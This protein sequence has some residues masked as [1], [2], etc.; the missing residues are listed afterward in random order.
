[1]LTHLTLAQ[2]QCL[3]QAYLAAQA[4]DFN[5]PYQNDYEEMLCSYLGFEPTPEQLDEIEIEIE[6]LLPSGPEPI[7]LPIRQ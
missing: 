5:D 1:M 2:T 3:A 6:E 7:Y 4:N